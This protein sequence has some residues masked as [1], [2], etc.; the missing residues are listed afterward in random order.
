[1]G[2][3]GEGVGE[4]VDEK[5]MLR[6]MKKWSDEIQNVLVNEGEELTIIDG[7]I[8]TSDGRE[9]LEKI[10]DNMRILIRE[11]RKY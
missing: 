3:D 4:N 10:E 11:L 9:I 6:L 1:M 5:D 2:Y 7:T 8:I